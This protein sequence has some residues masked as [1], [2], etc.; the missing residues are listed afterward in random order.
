MNL[1]DDY[2]LGYEERSQ[3]EAFIAHI[4]SDFGSISRQDFDINGKLLIKLNLSKEQL[5]FL[6]LNFAQHE[7]EQA[8]FKKLGNG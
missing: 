3:K 7:F 8:L 2:D 1:K 4:A 6:H 5:A